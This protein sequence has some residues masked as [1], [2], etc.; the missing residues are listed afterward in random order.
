MGDGRREG[1]GACGSP[2]L[3]AQALRRQV[4][5]GGRLADLGGADGI[6]GIGPLDGHAVGPEALGGD[7]ALVAAPGGGEEEQEAGKAEKRSKWKVVHRP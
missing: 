6:R 3:E 4:F 1:Q 2:F 7:D 5:V